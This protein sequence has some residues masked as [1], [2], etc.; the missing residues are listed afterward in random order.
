MRLAKLGKKKRTP[1]TYLSQ[2][3]KRGSVAVCIPMFLEVGILQQT[4][5]LIFDCKNDSQSLPG[6]EDYKAMTVIV[7]TAWD[8]L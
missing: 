2:K 8:T 6:L 1:F 5:G 3:R 7:V 4:A